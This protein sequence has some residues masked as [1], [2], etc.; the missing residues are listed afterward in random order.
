MKKYIK[1]TTIQVAIRIQQHLLQNSVQSVS[2]LDGV[3]KGDGDFDPVTMTVDSRR[4]SVWDE[5]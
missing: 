5:E 3:E 2:G 1:P 4:R